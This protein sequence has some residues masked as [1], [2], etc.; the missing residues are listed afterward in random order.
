MPSRAAALS[1]CSPAARISSSCT[2]AR[3]SLTCASGSSLALRSRGP[4]ASSAAPRP[5]FWYSLAM[6]SRPREF[7]SPDASSCS[8]VCSAGSSCPRLHLHLG[9][10]DERGSPLARRVFLGPRKPLVASVDRV[11]QVRCARRDQVVGCRRIGIRRRARQQLFRAAPVARS[12]VEQPALRVV[13][14]ASL[15][16]L[17]AQLRQPRAGARGPDECPHQ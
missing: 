6:S 12:E 2:W 7:R 5:S 11:L 15:A 16:S 1:A 9:Q 13:P 14:R 17:G 4:S 3:S 10:R 8:S